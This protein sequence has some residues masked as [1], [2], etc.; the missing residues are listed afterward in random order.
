MRSK[1]LREPLGVVTAIAV[2]VAV[3]VVPAPAKAPDPKALTLQLSDLPGGFSRTA[4]GYR[5]NARAGPRQQI[6]PDSSCCK[7][8]TATIERRGRSN[9]YE[10]TFESGKIK[11]GEPLAGTPAVRIGVSLYSSP[12]EARDA[13]YTLRDLNRYDRRLRHAS[14]HWGPQATRIFDVARIPQRYFLYMTTSEGVTNVFVWRWGTVVSYLVVA[15]LEADTRYE[16]M[17]VAMRQQV[18]IARAIA[19][20]GVISRPKPP[21]QPGVDPKLLGRSQSDYNQVAGTRGA[22]VLVGTPGDD[23]FTGLAGDD[24]IDAQG[25]NDVILGGSGDDVIEGG[26]GQDQ[27][28][29]E[30]GADRLSGGEDNDSIYGGPGDDEMLGG[31]GRDALFA[32]GQASGTDRVDGGPGDD[33]ASADPGRDTVAS[34]P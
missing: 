21:A 11:S 19:D 6:G 25:G 7:P 16:V 33:A 31:G 32:F 27:I 14:V 12:R 13:L 30:E 3:A 4:A 10:A 24:R 9:G 1:R 26:P 28:Y 34:I 2:V 5:P 15:G 23:Y 18:R 22:D 8:V 29:G 17:A 20:A